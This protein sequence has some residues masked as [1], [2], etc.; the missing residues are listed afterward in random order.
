MKKA[1]IFDCDGVLRTFSW[2]GVYEAYCAIGEYFNIDF[3]QKCPNVDVMRK[4]Y[5]HD[6]RRN[7]KMMGIHDEKHYPK[8]NEIFHDEYFTT[9]KMFAWVPEILEQLTCDHIVTVYSNSAAE[10]VRESLG[11]VAQNCAMI[12]GHDE[13]KKLKP[14]PEGILHIMET[15]DLAPE[16]AIMV[17]DSDVD[18]AA[19][20]RAGV[21]TALVT[22]GAVDSQEEINALAPCKTLQRPS[23]LLGLFNR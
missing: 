20:K 8:V 6:W 18:I 7:L 19:G 23:E 11:E 2:Q 14:E 10:S 21:R 16:N 22:W 15:F 12:V 5:S 3:T 13:V 1:I 9:V 4:T 17:G